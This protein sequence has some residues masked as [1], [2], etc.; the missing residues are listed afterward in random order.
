M[1][2]SYIISIYKSV[3][4]NWCGGV[5]VR[6]RIGTLESYFIVSYFIGRE[7]RGMQQKRSGS[8]TIFDNM[9]VEVLIESK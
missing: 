5:I 7:E 4:A 3:E 6:G 1:S 2:M 8:K 9:E